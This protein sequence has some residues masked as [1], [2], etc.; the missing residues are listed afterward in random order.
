MPLIY[1]RL[2]HSSAR[3]VSPCPTPST[4]DGYREDY[5][6]KED[7]F[8]ENMSIQ[9]EYNSAV[10]KSVLPFR[11][12]QLLRSYQALEIELCVARSVVVELYESGITIKDQAIEK[13]IKEQIELQHAHRK[14]HL[15]S[16][17]ME[18]KEI[19]DNM[20]APDANRN[21]LCQVIHKLENTD[22]NSPDFLLHSEGSESDNE[23]A[24]RFRY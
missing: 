8:N 9:R 1:A 4:A 23:V 22:T 3:S 10:E 24:K 6:F 7:H 15:E 5:G 12:D 18:K 19:Y 16:L 2:F 20:Y 21:N 17:I 14:E 11:Y 13:K